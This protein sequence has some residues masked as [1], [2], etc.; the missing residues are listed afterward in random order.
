[1]GELLNT[2]VRGDKYNPDEPDG[3]LDGVP[4]YLLNS[5]LHKESLRIDYGLRFVEF[6]PEFGRDMYM[7]EPLSA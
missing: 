1:M 5:R 4:Y 6:R 2:R 7:L 3:W